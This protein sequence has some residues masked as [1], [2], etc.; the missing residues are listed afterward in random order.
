M[1]AQ[2]IKLTEKKFTKAG[3]VGKKR[4]LQE[5]EMNSRERPEDTGL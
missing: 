5:G 3:A 1:P 4:K 2:L